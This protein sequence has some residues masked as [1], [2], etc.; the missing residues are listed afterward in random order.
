MNKQKSY[1]DDCKK[2]NSESIYKI[3]IIPYITVLKT[4]ILVLY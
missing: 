2:L 3:Y 1:A 4:H